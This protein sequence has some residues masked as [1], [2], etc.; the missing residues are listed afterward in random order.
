MKYLFEQ[1]KTM[2]QAFFIAGVAITGYAILFKLLK[3]LL[4]L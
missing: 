2:V 3:Y 1:I 4:N